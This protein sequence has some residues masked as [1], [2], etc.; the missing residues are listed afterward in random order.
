MFL[1]DADEAV[2]PGLVDVGEVFSGEQ[3]GNGFGVALAIHEVHGLIGDKVEVRFCRQ[4]FANRSEVCTL[5]TPPL[6]V[7]AGQS[8]EDCVVD[9]EEGKAARAFGGSLRRRLIFR[10]HVS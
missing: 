4:P 10:H 2:D 7:V 1:E 8:A 5:F 6:L 3:F 9:G